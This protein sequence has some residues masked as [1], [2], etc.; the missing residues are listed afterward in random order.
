M[1][2]VVNP[3]L[4]RSGEDSFELHSV[5]LELE[6]MEK[7]I[8]DLQVKQAKLRQRKATLES[9]TTQPGC[10][11]SGKRKPSTGRGPL[12]LH[13]HPPV[14]EISTQNYFATLRETECDTVIIGDSI[15][16]HVPAI[17]KKNI[18]AVVLHAGTNNI[19]LRQMEILKKDFRSL[20]EKVCTTS[21][22][23][24]IIVSGPLPMFQR[25]IERHFLQ[26]FRR[27]PEVLPGQPRDIVSPACP[28]SSPGPLPGGA[29]P[30]HL[31]R[32]TSRRRP[33]QMPEPPQLCPFD[34]E[35]QRLYSELLPGDRAPYP[36]S[37]GAACHPMEEAH[38]GRS[39]PGSYPFGHDPELMPIGLM[40]MLMLIVLEED[41]N[42]DRYVGRPGVT[43]APPWSQAWCWGT[44]ASAWWPSL[45][46]RDSAGHSPKKRRRPPLAGRSIRVRWTIFFS[47]VPHGERRRAGVGLLI[48]LQ[49]SRH[50]LEFSPV[51]ERVVS[52]RL[53]AGDRCLTVVSAYGPNGSVEYP[54]FLET[55]RG[56]LEGAPTG[57]SIVL[58]GDFNAHVGNDS[59][60]WRGMIGRNGPPPYLNSSGVLLLDFCASHSLSIMNTMFK[61]KGAHQYT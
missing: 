21:P 18:G 55:L 1:A 41:K 13:C 36:I 46:L 3:G 11:S 47:G 28:G 39:Y 45:C 60:T 20:V 4:D 33:K 19:R 23:T 57:D 40:L 22:T 50:V 14:F 12:L 24:R 44:Q 6:A 53:Q 54:T 34:V 26:L 58:L 59:D 25:R 16:R 15:V 52:L 37:K 32:E 8:R 29:C 30:E 43:G 17:L 10:S 42:E 38:F 48:A 2:V 5:D 51:N 61:H 35:E 56:V 9:G 7:Q 49:I 31:P 27:D